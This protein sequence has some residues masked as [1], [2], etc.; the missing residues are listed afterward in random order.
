MTITSA[1]RI[2]C[3][4]MLTLT[5]LAI[6]S[7]PSHAQTGA[8]YTQTLTFSDSPTANLALRIPGPKTMNTQTVIWLEFGSDDPNAGLPA[9]AFANVAFVLTRT[10]GVAPPHL[11]FNISQT[12]LA[13]SATFSQKTVVFAQPDTANS[14][15]LFTL[16]IVHTN[17]IANAT[18]EDWTLDM[19]GLP[20]TG[21]M[22][23]S[24]VI[25]FVDQGKAQSLTPTAVCGGATSCPPCPNVCPSGQACQGF[26]R[27]CVKFPIFVELAW[28]KPFPPDPP[29]LSCPPE[30]ATPIPDGFDRAMVGL[31]PRTAD[32]VR[33]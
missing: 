29:C 26:P 18:N 33:L 9:N 5:L 19:S 15:Q 12:S 11:D 22:P 2:V 31:I 28:P 7:F 25:S 13:D 4:G 1:T 10:G 8:K 14:P 23:H 32:G 27:P 3:V 30:W 24:R 17:G 6:C 16:V 21:T 20:A